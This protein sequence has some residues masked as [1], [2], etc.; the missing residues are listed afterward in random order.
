MDSEDIDNVTGVFVLF[1]NNLFVLF[2]YNLM[3]HKNDTY[4]TLSS[5]QTNR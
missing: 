3:L 5:C 2:V 4:I 1:F